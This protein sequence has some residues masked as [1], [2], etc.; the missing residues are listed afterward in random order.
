MYFRLMAAIID[1]RRAQTSDSIPTSLSVL[2]D[3]HMALCPS[4]FSVMG[5]VTFVHRVDKDA[6]VFIRKIPA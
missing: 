3:P 1:F 4:Q 2:P 6:V 5:L